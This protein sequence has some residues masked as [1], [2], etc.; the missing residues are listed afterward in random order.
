MRGTLYRAKCFLDQIA[1]Q[2]VPADL[3]P[4][5][6]TPKQREELLPDQAPVLWTPFLR[7]INGAVAF[8]AAPYKR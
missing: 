8:T 7:R 1:A 6:L 2:S 4:F 3:S 5:F